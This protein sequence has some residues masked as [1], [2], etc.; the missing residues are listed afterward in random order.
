MG[1]YNLILSNGSVL[2][3]VQGNTRNT[4]LTSLTLHG[5]GILDWG[6]ER[7][8]DLVYMLENFASA[9][10]PDNPLVGQLWFDL[11]ASS[12]G[13]ELTIY[14][15]EG[16][17]PWSALGDIYTRRDGD[18]LTGTLL[19][20]YSTTPTS[21]DPSEAASVGYVDTVLGFSGSPSVSNVFLQLDAANSPLTGALEIQDNVD[22]V[23]SLNRTSATE[24]H[25][26]MK[27]ENDN[28]SGFELWLGGNRNGST[29]ELKISDATSELDSGGDIVWDETRGVRWGGGSAGTQAAL[30]VENTAPTALDGNDGDIWFE[31]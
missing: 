17:P 6:G 19:L 25:T 7:D 24:T 9:T 29:T 30:Y 1:S 14:T 23:L 12:P 18:T 10:P 13:G 4:V 11:G 5:Q 20:S 22:V 3:T 8:Q 21:S 31:L 2:G 28:G 16:S 26:A 15:G 27:F